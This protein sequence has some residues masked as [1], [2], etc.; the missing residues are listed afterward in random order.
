MTYTFR[1]AYMQREGSDRIVGAYRRR[2]SLG[3]GQDDVQE[4]R[5]GGDRRYRLQSARRHGGG[6]AGWR[7]GNVSRRRRNFFD[8]CVT[9]CDG[10][11][12]VTCDRFKDLSFALTFE[13]TS[14]P[15]YRL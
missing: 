14:A 9:A 15:S 4:V 12:F 7:G 10:A 2:F 13:P 1:S 5:R 11:R 6:R 8:R 3:L